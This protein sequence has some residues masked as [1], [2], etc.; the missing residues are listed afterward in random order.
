MTLQATSNRKSFRADFTLKRPSVGSHVS[1]GV[2][3]CREVL[4]AYFALER[5]FPSVD[6]QMNL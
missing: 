5:F 2:T 3:G 4:I 1:H 6:S